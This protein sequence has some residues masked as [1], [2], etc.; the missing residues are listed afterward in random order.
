[1]RELI[2]RLEQTQDLNRNKIEL[3]KNNWAKQQN[4]QAPLNSDIYNSMTDEQRI[5]FRDLLTTKPTRT[6]SGVSV[7]AIMTKPA[8]CIGR[9]TYCPTS[10]LAPKSYTGYEPSSMRARRNNF[11]SYLIVKNR[12]EQLKKVGHPTDKNEV[13]IQG[14]TFTWMPWDYQY[15]FI[16]RTYDAFNN[17]DAKDLEDAKI[18]NETAD[19][20][21]VALVIETRPDWCKDEHIQKM[22]ELGATRCELGLQSVYDYVLDKI[23]R[24]HNLDE[25]K[26]AIRE[27][28]DAGFKVDLH[29]MLGLP[30]S[31]K[32][33]DIDMFRILFEDQDLRPE[34]GVIK[35]SEL[36]NI[37]KAGDY[38][39]IND[40]YILDV[41]EKIKPKYIPPYVRIKRIMRDIPS[42]HIEAG[43]K[44]LN[45]RQMLADKGVQCRCIR[46]REI[47]HKEVESVKPEL[48]IIEYNASN[49]KEYFISF[50]DKQSDSIIGFARLRLPEDTKHAFIREL[51]VYGQAIPLGESGEVQHKGLGKRLLAKAEQIAK[52]AGRDEVLVLSGVGVKEYYRKLGYTSKGH[53][54]SK[55]VEA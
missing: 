14:G 12:L 55:S 44:Y 54:M 49:G 23:K 50:D 20:R 52:D 11:D 34:C 13:I 3:I 31:S 51:H 10:E 29:M 38:E 42:D 6:L 45:I 26:R 16:K 41:L 5:K 30:G 24:G 48:N 47:G 2:Q 40:G 28:K 8:G 1:M 43:Y 25:A 46:C 39:P 22:L 19:H 18:I 9:C 7:I 17:I 4:I 37:W 21:V 33:L 15:N 36:Y 32:E 27:L 53:Y 35:G